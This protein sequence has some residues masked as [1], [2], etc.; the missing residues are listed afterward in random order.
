MTVYYRSRDV[1]ITTGAFVWRAADPARIYR[2][3]DFTFVGMVRGTFRHPSWELHA[4]IAGID[5]ILY[6][7]P[8]GQTFRQVARALVRAMEAATPLPRS[9]E[10][11][12]P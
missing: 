9:S 4:T 10:L 5:T 8:D 3:A 12:E 11:V 1:L 6:A 2:I 7:S